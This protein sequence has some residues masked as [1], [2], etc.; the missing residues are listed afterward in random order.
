MIL[1]VVQKARPSLSDVVPRWRQRIGECNMK[2]AV[3]SIT[4]T[5]VSV[6]ELEIVNRNVAVYFNNI[7]QQNR[8]MNPMGCWR[9]PRHG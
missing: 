9:L 4:E 7:P 1:D 6:Q 5:S 3:M 2:T 8:S